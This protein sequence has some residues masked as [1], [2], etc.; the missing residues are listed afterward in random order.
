MLQHS[1]DKSVSLCWHIMR[2]YAP[3]QSSTALVEDQYITLSWLVI[4]IGYP[5]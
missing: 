4:R 2:E 1:S 3:T 5:K